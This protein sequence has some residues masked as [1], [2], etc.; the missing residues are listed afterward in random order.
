MVIDSRHGFILMVRKKVMA[1]KT[2]KKKPAHKSGK[3]RKRVVGGNKPTLK[4]NSSSSS[5]R[6]KKLALKKKA[7][8]RKKVAAKKKLAPK[9]KLAA[10]K[11]PIRRKK[12]SARIKQEITNRISIRGRRGVGAETGGQSGDTQGLSRMEDADSESVEELLEEGQ[13]FEA[14]A[15]SGV[16]NAK[17]PDESK[18]TTSEVPEDDVPPEYTERNKI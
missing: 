16:E 17:D 2:I 3:N 10:K 18:V 5:S 14:E 9:K 8:P 6:R 1:K 12:S 13:S 4:K 7:A 15:V 11:K